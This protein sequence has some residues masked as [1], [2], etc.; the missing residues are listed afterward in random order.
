MARKRSSYRLRVWRPR[1]GLVKDSK[2]VRRGR[3]LAHEAKQRDENRI[4]RFKEVQRR[5][6]NWIKFTQIA[7]AYSEQGGPGAAERAYAMLQHDLLAGNFEEN[8][9]SQV[10]YLFPGVTDRR[11]T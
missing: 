3:E 5:K 1:Y 9:R 11:M 10:L 4:R 7:E 2:R 6:C 8:G